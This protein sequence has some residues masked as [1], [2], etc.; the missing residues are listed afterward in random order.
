MNNIVSFTT[1]PFF[2]LSGEF[3]NDHLLVCKTYF[4]SGQN[5]KETEQCKLTDVDGFLSCKEQTTPTLTN[6]LGYPELFFVDAAN[7]TV[8]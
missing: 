7:C 2:L 6:Y 3:S 5:K 4:F 1:G 8:Q